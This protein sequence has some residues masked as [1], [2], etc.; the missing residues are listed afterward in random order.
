MKKIIIKYQQGAEVAKHDTEL[1]L[2]TPVLL[3]PTFNNKQE[4]LNFWTPEKVAQHPTLQKSLAE[5]YESL[6]YSEE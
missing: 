4:F 5:E 2:S 3:R 6:P 1:E